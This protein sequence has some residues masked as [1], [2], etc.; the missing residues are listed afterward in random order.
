MTKYA[1]E[2]AT[3]F[4][5]LEITQLDAYI[6]TL[7]ISDVKI[8]YAEVLPQ[9]K[10]LE[11]RKQ[12]K[13]ILTEYEKQIL[14]E[15]KQQV[16]AIELSK[17]DTM[18]ERLQKVYE[19][20]TKKALFA[21]KNDEIRKLVLARATDDELFILEQKIK[22]L[23]D[24]QLIAIQQAI[25]EVNNKRV[26]NP[27]K[28]AEW[29]K[30]HANLQW[31]VGIWEKIVK[32]TNKANLEISSRP[33]IKPPESAPIVKKG[34]LSQMGD[35]IK[36][37]VRGT[38]TSLASLV[39][40]A[41]VSPFKGYATAVGAVWKAITPKR[42]KD[43]GL[44]S[45][46]ALNAATLIFSL[47][48]GTVG[49]IITIPAEY[50]K[51]ITKLIG[52]GFKYLYGKFKTPNKSYELKITE[53]EADRL[54]VIAQSGADETS[55]KTALT[56]VG[57]QTARTPEQIRSA[58]MTRFGMVLAS[59]VV[60]G[61]QTEQHG[62]IGSVIGSLVALGDTNVE[63]N[64]LFRAVRSANPGGTSPFKI[65]D[66]DHAFGIGGEPE[67]V[68]SFERSLMSKLV[69]SPHAFEAYGLQ[70]TKEERNQIAA[71]HNNQKRSENLINIMQHVCGEW[72]G[73][74]KIPGKDDYRKLG[75]EE[76][77]KGQKKYQA[78]LNLAG[79]ALQK[80]CLD[81]K[82][83]EALYF[84]TGLEGHAMQLVIKREGN[85]FK[86]STYDSSGALENT[87][88]KGSLVGLLK[89]SRMGS[90]GMRKNALSF[91]V[92]EERLNSAE[93][94]A[95][96]THLIHSKSYAGWAETHIEG[97]VRHTSMEERDQMGDSIMGRIR[98]A[99][100]LNDQAYVYQRYI[101][102]FSSLAPEDA[103][104]QF[105]ELLQRPQNTGNCYAK[106]AQSN[107]LYELGKSTY[108]KVRLAMLLEQRAALLSE[109]CGDKKGEQAFVDAE[110]IPM[111]K[112][113][114]PEYLSPLELHEASMRLTE[115]N[116]PPSNQYY[117]N[118][119]NS[120]LDL[121]EQL[122]KAPENDDNDL[123]IRRI[124]QKIANH[125]KALYFYLKSAGRD[126]EIKE[127]FVPEVYKDDSFSWDGYV[128]P[129]K[130]DDEGN[131]LPKALNRL[132]E[133]AT[134][135]AW[136]ASLQVLN[137]QIQKLSVNERHIHSPDQR[138]E[139][140]SHWRASGKVTLKDLENA[141]IVSFVT[142]FARNEDTKIEINIGRTRKEIDK[143]TFFRLV[144][145]NKEALTNPR[146]M[147]LLDALRN[148]KPEIEK[149]YIQE[150]YPV[151]RQAFIEKLTTN[152]EQVALNINATIRRLEQ[153]QEKVKTLMVPCQKNIDH[154]NEEISKEQALLGEGNKSVK[155]QNLEA[156]AQLLTQE[157][158]ELN[159]L[160]ISVSNKLLTLRGNNVE[161]AKAE[162]ILAKLKNNDPELNTMNAVS[163]AFK[164]AMNEL[165]EV[166]KQLISRV[167]EFEVD[168]VE[169]QSNHRLQGLR[170][171]RE[172]IISNYLGTNPGYRIIDE[173]AMGR[174]GTEKQRNLDLYSQTPD[175]REEFY[176]QGKNTFLKGSVFQDIQS[177]NQKFKGQITGGIERRVLLSTDTYA[178]NSLDTMSSGNSIYASIEEQA[179]TITRPPISSTIKTEWMK[180]MFAIWLRH[181]DKEK[182]YSL[183]KKSNSEIAIKEAFRSFLHQKANIKFAALKET[184]FP[185]DL[186]TQDLG[187]KTITEDEMV[188]YRKIQHKASS[189][190]AER[191]KSVFS[192]PKQTIERE[193]APS[194]QLTS[195]D[196]IAIHDPSVGAQEFNAPVD[197]EFV[198]LYM[199]T[200]IDG[201]TLDFLRENPTPLLPTELTL[202]KCNEYYQSVNNYLEK[203][204]GHQGLENKDQRIMEFCHS[205]A[206]NI[207]ILPF[208][209]DAKLVTD[210]STSMLARYRDEKGS[211]DKLFMKLEN[212]QRAQILTNLIQLNLAQ[213]PNTVGS[214]IKVD[215]KFYSTIKHWERLIIPKDKAMSERIAAL[216]PGG[217]ILADNSLIESVD[218]SIQYSPI[219]L[220]GILEGQTGQQI[221]LTDYGKQKQDNQDEEF[222]G[223]RKLA[224][225]LGMR[226]GDKI[227]A[228]Q[229]MQFYDEKMLLSSDGLNSTA[230]RELFIRA[231]IDA[232]VNATDTEKKELLQHIEL[233]QFDPEQVK[234]CKLMVSHEIFLEEVLYHASILDPKA[235]K[236]AEKSQ[237]RE[238]ALG[239]SI[240]FIKDC[241]DPTQKDGLKRLFGFAKEIN[242]IT[243]QIESAR[244][245]GAP[246]TEID[247]L[248]AKLI[249]SNLAYQLMYDQTPEDTLLGI[250]KNFEITREMA[251]AQTN[252][253]KEQNHIIQFSKDLR[254]PEK[255]GA[256]EK[257]FKGYAEARKFN[258]MMVSLHGKPSSFSV[259]GFI[260]LGGI[261]SLDTLHGAIYIGANKMGYMP[262]HIQSNIALEIL[263]IHRLPFKPKDGGYL[264][265]E[266]KKIKASITP[267]KDGSLIIQ[268]ELKTI[269][270]KDITLQ[271]IP[272]EKME[273]ALPI[274]LRRRVNADHFF[275]DKEGAI[276][277]FSADFTPVL[278]VSKDNGIWSGK[279]LDKNKTITSIVLNNELD[280]IKDLSKIF[281]P[282]EMIAVDEDTV[283]VPSI[284]KF[285]IKDETSPN[286][287]IADS[288]TDRSSRKYFEVTR[289][290]AQFCKKY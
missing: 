113:L 12:I 1:G 173:L 187:W 200:V 132:S 7:G 75:P 143:A 95:Y 221:A 4:S 228:H 150:V 199:D 119:F 236:G 65:K 136:K 229:F 3:L 194:V 289:K 44:G 205:V 71:Y 243:L 146:V 285:I 89:L 94:L 66:G 26:L 231:F 69:D 33:V 81:L 159:A 212:T 157:V 49:S 19:N 40:W 73:Y 185:I 163:R 118:Y 261:N 189:T 197:I 282:E 105:E 123:A 268:R 70:F 169:Q 166:R 142:G 201:S 85:Q 183:Q 257:E 160:K 102:R 193:S 287:F 147:G 215:S 216:E 24:E 77:E 45:W 72:G 131:I 286:Y 263:S 97:N 50:L 36:T 182:L 144:V 110:Y 239:Q 52:E 233:I 30:Q 225:R 164:E 154:L 78:K 29:L 139:H 273:Q 108:K 198:P 248:Y 91:K 264:Y 230:G 16:L 272:S 41:I 99:F 80:G 253:N 214:K 246:Q 141:N 8:L 206:A 51:P 98:R 48:L 270:G 251:L 224:D 9:I 178:P 249:C 63:K 153:D 133:H 281:P 290:E 140:A 242:F 67:M 188:K 59:Q 43:Q 11:R 129:F 58:I 103:P 83:G 116:E 288:K 20:L 28:P 247:K 35:G 137:H 111:L 96:L 2:V 232:F 124:E 25:D 209:P 145:A 171:F 55:A 274:S 18:A 74:E 115:I 217:S 165:E 27:Q 104:P 277:A 117:Q 186:S 151:Q 172:K 255:A 241:T 258:N 23:K 192:E 122:E 227:L 211:F 34:L 149:K 226:N 235:F 17:T 92:S 191:F 54:K 244:A 135:L 101:E 61:T 127:Y 109:I 176:K 220:E 31:N 156:R 276:H 256:F 79:K 162:L 179:K 130:E 234:T 125:A 107:E 283:Y 42:G 271:Y 90:R 238:V 174:M 267:Q 32:N 114:D 87:T 207:L 106:K 148:S 88:N 190:I 68:T 195:S 210:F 170:V 38:V 138:L 56:V 21:L 260:S 120:L 84:E 280:L 62:S 237:Q 112:G 13:Q 203:L 213:I 240:A 64:S 279:L 155:L 254:D 158:E 47:P 161:K 252:I 262:A 245:N 128:L 168:D 222:T 5:Y 266:D 37:V 76:F 180:E 196:L 204:K 86:L 39:K 181:E 57:E 265:T 250:G 100:A 152:I 82:D 278:K 223:L 93:G 284:S 167:R 275:I 202:E 53:Q 126:G 15:G 218:S 219:G 208:S 177:L 46:V 184:G 121:K 14:A 134:A 22:S 10:D 60:S 269:D 259:P 175:K 6:K